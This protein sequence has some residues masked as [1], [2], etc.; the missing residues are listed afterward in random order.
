MSKTHW[1]LSKILTST[2]KKVSNTLTRIIVSVIAIPLI[3][4]LCYWGGIPFLLLVS[5]I[6][7]IAFWEFSRMG[8]RKGL[9]IKP[10]FGIA[11]V[12]ILILN[13]YFNFVQTEI[14]FIVILLFAV[15]LK[16]F[17]SRGSAI[18]DTGALLLGI[19]YLGLFASALIK[20]REFYPPASLVYERGG[21][22]IISILATIWICDSAAFFLGTAF[23]KH[24]LY[25]RIS[26]KKS[27]EGAIAGFVFSLLAMTLAKYTVLDF[28]TWFQIIGL[29]I[30]IGVF[31]Q[32]GDLVESMFKRDADVKDS[33][34]LIPGHGGI[35]DRFDSLLFTAP[36][37]Y[38][39]LLYTT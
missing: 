22:L 18:I 14:I 7:T 31:G 26:P 29:G 17:D 1:Q 23:G 10:I 20:I 13:A 19:S 6:G 11:S 38:I 5:G 28:L 15:L 34:A 27:W 21:Y 35:F 8:E 39:F 32:I 37:I 36:I 24:R 4:A 2:V 33:S 9:V 25:E 30:I 16:L 12:E 3:L